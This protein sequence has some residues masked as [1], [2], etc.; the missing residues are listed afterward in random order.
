MQREAAL[1]PAPSPLKAV[2]AAYADHERWFEGMTCA[3]RQ[4]G[5]LSGEAV[6]APAREGFD[7]PER[8][9][10]RSPPNTCPRAPAF[11]TSDTLHC[12]V[13]AHATSKL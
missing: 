6:G 13:D 11:P 1:N 12:C 10:L 7:P 4:S 2:F 9:E 5:G 3:A 8:I